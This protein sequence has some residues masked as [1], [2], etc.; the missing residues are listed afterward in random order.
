MQSRLQERLLVDP[1]SLNICS[2]VARKLKN[3][4]DAPTALSYLSLSVAVAC[5][6][7]T[8][9]TGRFRMYLADA[10]TLLV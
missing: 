7:H 3:A 2:G 8:F 5:G 10:A 4:P 9:T 1:E 6:G